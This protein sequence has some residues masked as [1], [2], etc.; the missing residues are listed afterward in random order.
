[1][2]NNTRTRLAV[3]KR[4][5]LPSLPAVDSHYLIHLVCQI[6]QVQS[7][8][9]LFDPSVAITPYLLFLVSTVLAVSAYLSSL[10]INIVP[11]ASFFKLE[12]V[13]MARNAI[14]NVCVSHALCFREHTNNRFSVTK[15]ACQLAF[16]AIRFSGV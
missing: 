16:I 2:Y 9:T 3:P 10:A 14:R 4:V 5:L 6:N 7:S 15:S 1:M 13:E 11:L 12:L 8:S